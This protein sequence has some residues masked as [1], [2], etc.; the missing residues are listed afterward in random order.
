M[1]L[2]DQSNNLVSIVVMKDVAGMELLALYC[3]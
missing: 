2:G 1:L 3:R